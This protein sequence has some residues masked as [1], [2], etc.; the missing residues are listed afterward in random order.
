MPQE[1]ILVVDD[2]LFVRELLFEFLTKQGYEVVL[3][4]SGEKALE[5]CKVQPSQVVLV[6][7]KMPGM[8]GIDTLKEIKQINSQALPI[9]MTGYPTLETS[10]EALRAGA[11]DYVI[12]PFKLNELKSLIERALKEFHLRE[13]IGE[14]RQRIKNLEDDL[15]KHP[16]P[17]KSKASSSGISTIAGGALYSKNSKGK[18]SSTTNH[19]IEQIKKLGEL[20]EKGLLTEK[21]FEEKKTELLGRL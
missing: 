11:Y 9:I 21:E 5:L 3:A 12:K 8:N 13:E 20:K 16:S 17:E 2:E 14:L 18:D 1:K 19:I 10:L 15:K 6:D 4:E 7:L